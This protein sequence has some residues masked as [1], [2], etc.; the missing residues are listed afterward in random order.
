MPI[1]KIFG[2]GYRSGA[3]LALVVFAG[4]AAA[5]PRF[6][7]APPLE[8]F[9][10]AVLAAAWQSGGRAGWATSAL[11]AALGAWLLSANLGDGHNSLRLASL[12]ATGGLASTVISCRASG[13]LASS[14]RHHAEAALREQEHFAAKVVSSSLN[15]L[16][17]FDSG[18]GA[19]RFI[20]PQFTA[21][22]GYAL[23]DSP[24]APESGLLGGFLHP[25]D[26]AR[27]QAHLDAL[28]QAKD[29]EALE[30]ECRLRR[31]DGE[32]RWFL[33]RHA[34]FSRG[35]GGALRE[36]LGGPW[37]RR[38]PEQAYRPRRP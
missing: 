20:N 13:R 5:G 22:T 38:H 23:E 8:L 10:V 31:A 21:L 35:P 12:L 24:H 28:R 3:L 2:N 14:A 17:I 7:N 32:W 19:L 6:G 27:H 37:P 15:G 4:L 18:T 34:V 16:Y 11:S 30:I 26:Q 33:C 1:Q 36:T 25:D 9:L 29:D